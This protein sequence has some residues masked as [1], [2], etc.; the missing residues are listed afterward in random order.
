MCV[1]VIVCRQGGRSD[2]LNRHLLISA[3]ATFPLMTERKFK[4]YG[5]AVAV[6]WFFVF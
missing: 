4:Y 5:V 6:Y 1:C 3:G 2:L